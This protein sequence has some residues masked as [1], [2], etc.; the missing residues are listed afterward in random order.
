MNSR[1]LTGGYL[2]LSERECIVNW[3]TQDVVVSARTLVVVLS[4]TT[5]SSSSSSSSAA[6]WR[7]LLVFDTATLLTVFVLSPRQLL[8]LYVHDTICA[9]IC[10]VI[11]TGNKVVQNRLCITTVVSEVTQFAVAAIRPIRT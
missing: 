2:V 4:S 8:H 5:A 10:H 11:R 1:S 7:R 3:H 6:W 9:V